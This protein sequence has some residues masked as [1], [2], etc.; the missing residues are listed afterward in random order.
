MLKWKRERLL[1]AGASPEGLILPDSMLPGV[2]SENGCPQLLEELAWRP[3]G[4]GLEEGKN[5]GR[6]VVQLLA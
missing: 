1:K 6:E 5:G 2:K 3:G 4:N